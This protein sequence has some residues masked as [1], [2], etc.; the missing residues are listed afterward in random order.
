MSLPTRKL[1]QRLIS[2]GLC[3]SQLRTTRT[4]CGNFLCRHA[5][6]LPFRGRFSVENS[7]SL[8]ACLWPIAGINQLGASF[9]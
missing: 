4:I 2:D 5:W 6:R 1:E 9:S 3:N 7:Q 8:C